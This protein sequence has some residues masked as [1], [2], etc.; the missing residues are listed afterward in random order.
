MPENYELWKIFML[1]GRDICAYTVKDEFE[2]EEQNTKLDLAAQYNTSVANITTK[3]RYMKEESN[4][5]KFELGQ[6]LMTIGIADRMKEDADFGWFVQ[7]SLLR[8]EN[9]DWGNLCEEDVRTNLHALQNGDRLM[10]VY[11]RMNYPS[12][13]IWIITEAD[14]SAT[15]VLYPH[16]Y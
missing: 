10:S 15:T 11:N 5:K 7:V 8:H 14:R 12:D 6:T 13:T 16:E 4:V 3:L 1:D 2:E 9:G